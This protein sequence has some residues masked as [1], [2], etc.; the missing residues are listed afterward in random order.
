MPNERIQ[1]DKPMTPSM[2]PDLNL[3]KR[4][5]EEYFKLM[6]TGNYN[7]T[8]ALEE[9]SREYGG[10]SRTTLRHYLFPSDMQ[11]KIKRNRR[12]WPAQRVD[13]QVLEKI[14]S[15]KKD[16]MAARRHIDELVREAYQRVAPRQ[17][18]YLDELAY[19]IQ[20]KSG[21]LFRPNTLL[22][23]SQ[24][25]EKNTGKPLLQEVKGCQPLRYTLYSNKS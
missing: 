14:F 22:G 3:P 21:V 23:L 20:D 5:N 6:A 12:Q 25:Y 13:P 8:E 11:K 18:L 7:Q 15:Y 9:I 10:V 17:E 16:Y 24:Q 2:Y 4:W 19:L 1:P